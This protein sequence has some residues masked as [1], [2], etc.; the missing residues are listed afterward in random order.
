M[1]RY[2]LDTTCLI[3]LQRRAPLAGAIAEL[4]AGPHVLGACAITVAEFYTGIRPGRLPAMDEFIASLRYWQITAIDAMQAGAYRYA[5]AR[6]GFQL[7][8]TDVLI[9]AVARRVGA[10]VLTE[11]VKDFPM[12]DI[13]A[14]S[15]T[16]L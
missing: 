5:F 10:T 12:D 11:N 9:A 4:A 1:T 3:R 16:S 7:S 2:L 15:L 6:R 14:L 8:M 13:T